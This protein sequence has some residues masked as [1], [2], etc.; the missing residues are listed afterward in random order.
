[1]IFRQLTKGSFQSEGYQKIMYSDKESQLLAAGR[2]TARF[3]KKDGVTWR[4][5]KPSDAPWYNGASESPIKSVK[6]NL[7][8]TIENSVLTLDELQTSLFNIANM[9][10]EYPI[11]VKP[12]FSLELGTYLCPDDLLLGRATVKYPQKTYETNTNHTR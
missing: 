7:Y 1:M 3:G 6:R 2:E 12:G 4:L 10:N 5:S 11:G 9:M 8:I